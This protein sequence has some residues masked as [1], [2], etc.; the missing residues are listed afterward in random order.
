MRFYRTKAGAYWGPGGTLAVS[1]GPPAA[2]AAKML[3]PERPCLAVCGD[4]GMAMQIHVLSTALQYN[5]PV[6]FLIFNDSRLGMVQEWQKDRAIGSEFIPTDFA[7]IARG[8]GCEGYRITSPEELSPT[9]LKAYSSNTPVVL[10][11]HVNRNEKIYE[12]LY[13]PLAKEVMA[14]LSRKKLYYL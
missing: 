4:G 6:V 11:V 12:K 8:F 14:L 7:A 9:L 5:A 3:F 13:S 1:Y 2:V 10:D